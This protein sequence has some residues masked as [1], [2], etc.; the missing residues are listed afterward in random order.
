MQ[1]DDET[2]E[3]LDDEVDDTDISLSHIVYKDSGTFLIRAQ[4]SFVH[5][6]LLSSKERMGI[7]MLAEPRRTSKPELCYALRCSE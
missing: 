1:S 6:R 3:E 2:H 5:N 7:C 4:V